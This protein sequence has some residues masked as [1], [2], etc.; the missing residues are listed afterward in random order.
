MENFTFLNILSNDSIV[1]KFINFVIKKGYKLIGTYPQAS[2][3]LIEIAFK[4]LYVIDKSIYEI[5]NALK[6]RDLKDDPK[7]YRIKWLKELD[8]K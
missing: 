6:S 2:I 1:S 5:I 7:S 4:K 8:L 3:K